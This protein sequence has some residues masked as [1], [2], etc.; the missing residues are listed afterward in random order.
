MRLLLVLCLSLFPGVAMALSCIAPNAGR[1]LN[2]AAE[3]GERLTVVAGVLLP[4]EGLR[5]REGYETFTAKYR[6]VG[7]M[8]L[9]GGRDRHFARDITFRSSCMLDQWCGP[10]PMQATDAVFL[11]KDQGDQGLILDT[12]PCPSAIFFRYGPD[13]IQALRECLTHGE[14]G[15]IDLRTLDYRYIR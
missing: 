12:N 2:D 14:C 8:L 11:L 3:R 6:L 13:Q 7:T 4:P 5:G 10:V 15:P 9:P 1:S